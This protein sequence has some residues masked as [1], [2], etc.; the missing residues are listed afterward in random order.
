MNCAEVWVLPWFIDDDGV[1]LLTAIE[2]AGVE[3]VVIRGRGVNGSINVIEDDRV[4]HPHHQLYRV[5]GV[6]VAGGRLRRL[7]S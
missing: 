5:G 7:S 3:G 1:T 4:V 2:Y 6:R